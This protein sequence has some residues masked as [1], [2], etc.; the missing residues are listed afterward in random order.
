MSRLEDWSVTET[1]KCE[2]LKNSVEY[3]GFKID[4]Q[5][6]HPTDS[7]VEAIISAPAPTLTQTSQS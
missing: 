1:V 4:A 7:K 5:G 2:F 3:L 6:K